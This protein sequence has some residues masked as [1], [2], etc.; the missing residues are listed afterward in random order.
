MSYGE[1][2]GSYGELRVSY[3]ELRVSYGGFMVS[4]KS[5]FSAS[6]FS[7]QFLRF[8]ITAKCTGTVFLLGVSILL[9]P[10]GN[11]VLEREGA[12][13]RLASHVD[14]LPQPSW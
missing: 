5:F 7:I 13:A 2:R 14:G 6:S 11:R 1:L 12:S 4:A 10:F 3:S 8:S 9:S